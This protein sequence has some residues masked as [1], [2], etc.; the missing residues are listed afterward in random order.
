MLP[1][2][3][4]VRWRLGG[5]PGAESYREGHLPGAVFVDLDAELCGPPGPRGG[6]RC[7]Q[8]PAFQEVMRRAGVSARR[9]VVVYDDADAT[10]AARA[11][12]TLRYF[13]HDA[14][15]VLDGGYPGVVRRGPAGGVGDGAAAGATGGI[16]PPCPAAWRHSTRTRRPGLPV[17]ACCSTRGRQRDTGARWSRSIP[18]PGTSR[19][20]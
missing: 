17:M 2:V 14:V 3:L 7:R 9:P 18:W 13:G 4:D 20:R 12:W 11:W 5:P 6:T 15:A 10:A 8:P 1:V 16:S 19:E